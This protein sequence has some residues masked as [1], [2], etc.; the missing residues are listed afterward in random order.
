V[1]FE[2]V[3]RP[4]T[5]RMAVTLAR[6]GGE[7]NLYGGCAPGTTVELSTA[8][9]HYAELRLQGSYHHTPTAVRRALGLL[10]EGRA[11]YRELLGPP[12]GL[13]E[14]PAALSASG[15]KRPVLPT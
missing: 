15:T 9:L 1:V 7:V 3:G 5:W 8:E 11:P 13:A 2:A 14:V 10:A 12:I 4:E 6:P